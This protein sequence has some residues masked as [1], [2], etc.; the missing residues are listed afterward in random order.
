MRGHGEKEAKQGLS[1]RVRRAPELITNR[2]GN[3]KLSKVLQYLIPSTHTQNELDVLELILS[4]LLSVPLF[5]SFRWSLDICIPSMDTSFRDVL[6]EWTEV[7]CRHLNFH[8]LMN[9][10]I[11]SPYKVKRNNFSSFLKRFLFI[12]FQREGK[13]GRK[14]GRETSIGCLSHA[15]NLGPGRQPIHVP[16]LGIKPETYWFAEQCPTHWATQ[17]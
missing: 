5:T 6:E 3:D 2:N 12:Y 11:W 7:Q 1:F 10:H 17:G 8:F 16:W 14:R 15:P 9:K 13:G 4:G